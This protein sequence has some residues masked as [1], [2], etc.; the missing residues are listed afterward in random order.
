MFCS[1]SVVAYSPDIHEH[2]G[3]QT[4]NWMDHQLQDTRAPV[5]MVTGL[6][7]TNALQHQVFG[8]VAV[9]QRHV[10]QNL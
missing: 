8:G 4:Q 9:P 6:C 7:G 2:H 5:V 10:A 3:P 1:S